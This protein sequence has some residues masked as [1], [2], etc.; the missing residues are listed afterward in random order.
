MAGRRDDL[1]LSGSLGRSSGAFIPR[2]PSPSPSLTRET[3][4]A[5]PLLSPTPSL[6]AVNASAPGDPA[7]VTAP[8]KYVPYTPKH[9]TSATTGTTLQSS[10]SVSPQQQGGGAAGKLQLMN[11]KAGAQSIG[12]EAGSVGWEILEKLVAEHD[13][14][15][16]WGE[17]WNTVITGKATLLLP[18]EQTSQDITLDFVKDHIAFTDGASKGQIPVVTLSGIRGAL[19]GETVTF[20]SS[21]LPNSQPFVDLLSPST[22]V[23]ALASLPPLPLISSSPL[24]Q[25]YPTYTLSAYTDNLPLPPHV[26]NKPPLPPRPGARPSSSQGTASSR[27]S[28]SFAS[29][30]G[31]APT[32]SSPAPTP[33]QSG[34]PEHAVEVSA[35]A[36]DRR[37]IHKDVSKVINKAL[38][39]EIK[40]TLSMSSVPSWV[41]ERVHDFTIGLYPFIK[42]SSSAKIT[43]TSPNAASPA[44]PY[45]IDPPQETAEELSQQFQE[46]YAELEEDLFAGH[47]P[48]TAR[49]KG[50]N[51]F[52]AEQEKVKE[53][54]ASGKANGESDVREILE[55]VERVIS[56]LCYDRLYL[57]AKSDDASHDEALSSRVA[58]LNMLDL[59][60]DHL[61]VEVGSA[62]PEV[63]LVLES[64]GETLSQLELP[65]CRCPADKGS[66]IVAAHKTLVDGL[67][68]LPP[69]RLKSEA[70]LEHQKTPEAVHSDKDLPEEPSDSNH[71]GLREASDIDPPPIV[72]SPDSD[73]QI[74]PPSPPPT[75]LSGVSPASSVTPLPN[76]RSTSPASHVSPPSSP[77]P[78]SGDIIVPLMIFAVVKANPQHLVSHLLYTQRFRNQRFGG[79]ESYCLVN[80]MAVADFLE[81]VD[82]KALGLGESE[83]KVMSTADL[84]PIPVTRA[85]L[86]GQPSDSPE[87]V[88]ARLR[89]GVEQQV[90]A[91]AGSA[92]RVLSGVVDQGFGVLRAL[93]PGTTDAQ[94]PQEAAPID[95]EA[96]PWNAVRPGFGLL[97]R[98]SG[99]SIA[100]LA[101]SLPGRD[102]AKSFASSIAP[103][104]EESGQMMVEV[105]SRPGSIRSAYASDAEASTGEESE[106]LDEDDEEYDDDEERHDARSIRSF[107][108]MMGKTRRRR[109]GKSRKSI[110]DRLASVTGLSRLSGAPQP[111]G[112]V[113]PTSGSPPP[114]RRSSLLP[115]PRA[116]P[117]ASRFDTPASSRA[118]SPVSIRIAAPNKRFLECTE[119]DIKVSEVKELLREY[120]RVVEGMRAMGG[121]DE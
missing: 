66:I 49:P 74:H 3:L 43:F 120:K 99:F 11:L 55:A 67:S 35:Y 41:I 61:G 13:S 69:I 90:D 29:L 108:S 27:L 22:R 16:E 97:R 91:I 78:V 86:G 110:S 14:S 4:T 17:V 101:A 81:N 80:L 47:S 94:Q 118:P 89:R 42:S 75:D 109:Q 18:L 53:K 2:I 10:L 1:F 95:Q 25:T 51:S 106:G 77:T 31:K 12:L 45:V 64:C 46:F 48:V 7:D 119:D 98:E 44:P 59:G 103:T 58:A 6:T 50:D 32:S 105:S 85:A 93:L 70:E 23:Q 68:R 30:F 104:V 79:E 116:A 63:H 76:H 87:G 72:I 82:L 60:L 100:S 114:S 56:S 33:P 92:N 71:D 84:T 62:G 19:V 65:A 57:Q 52:E 28:S 5:H 83:K 39:S 37:I 73:S 88:P 54:R 96:A 38:K 21:L 113:Q 9:R 15:P 24:S 34:E 40:E 111:V 107:E 8:T 117:Q 20:R 121:F 102:R 115:P 36:I 26:L 112:T